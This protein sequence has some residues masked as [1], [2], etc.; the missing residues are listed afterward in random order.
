MKESDFQHD[1]IE[2]IEAR[3]P[4][5]FVLKNDS[6]YCQGVP[7]FLILYKDRWATL[8]F[9]KSRRAHTQPNQ[10]YYV[11]MLNDMSFSAFIFPENKEEVLDDLERSLKRH[12]R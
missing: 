6:R 4:G 8:E 12:R 10:R 11:D 9:K 2:E 1:T 5:C 7:D 3:L